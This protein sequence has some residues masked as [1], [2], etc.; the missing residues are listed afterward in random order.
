[1]KN[2]SIEY[3]RGDIRDKSFLES[4]NIADATNILLLRSSLYEDH[5]K[6]DAATLFTLINL[7]EIRKTK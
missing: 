2:I 7:R 6:A 5:E 4:I 1:M 3:K